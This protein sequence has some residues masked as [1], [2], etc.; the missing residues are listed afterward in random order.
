MHACGFHGKRLKLDLSLPYILVTTIRLSVLSGN[1]TPSHN[2]SLD[3]TWVGSELGGT[4]P[5][6][7]KN[8]CFIPNEQVSLSSLA[9]I[10]TFMS[11]KDRASNHLR[12]LKCTLPSVKSCLTSPAFKITL[13]QVQ[14]SLILAVDCWGHLDQPFATADVVILIGSSLYFELDLSLGL[15]HT[16]NC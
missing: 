2:H 14:R 5:T 9:K 15:I 13:L 10:P 4:F 1:N 16:V 12:N 11:L 8:L 3:V 6:K 7:E